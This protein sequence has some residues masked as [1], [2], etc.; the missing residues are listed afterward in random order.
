M[1]LL[2]DG[3]NLLRTWLKG[4]EQDIKSRGSFGE[5]LSEELQRLST[6][7][8]NPGT[9]LGALRRNLFETGKDAVDIKRLQDQ[10]QLDTMGASN[11]LEG[12]GKALEQ[13]INAQESILEKTAETD[14]ARMRAKGEIL[15]GF[16]QG[17][18]DFGDRVTAATGSRL[19]DVL[20]FS[21]RQANAD[22]ALA[23]QQFGA[24]NK[25]DWVRLLLGGLLTG[26]SLFKG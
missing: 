26:A 7:A 24:G 6:Q 23:E 19:S 22:R 4:K 12:R 2:G 8:A 18:I 17:N 11:L 5:K 10:A 9:D 14:I 21:E 25:L 13:N 20:G 1:E 3:Y 15:G 16:Q